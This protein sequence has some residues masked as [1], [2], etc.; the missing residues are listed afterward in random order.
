VTHIKESLVPHPSRKSAREIIMDE[1]G[2][3][4]KS[5]DGGLGVQFVA[6]KQG[7]RL[8]ELQC[9]KLMRI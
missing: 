6:V 7:D 2:E 8:R 5:E 9:V 3:L 1:L 4:E